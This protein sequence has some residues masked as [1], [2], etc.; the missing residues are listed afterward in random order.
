MFLFFY[1]EL[2]ES[3]IKL[4]IQIFR[5]LELLLRLFSHVLEG[6]HHFNLLLECSHLYLDL[7]RF[8][9][10]LGICQRL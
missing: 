6:I 3:L 8:F 5:F 7:Y 9:L 2:T 10:E 1:S 4:F